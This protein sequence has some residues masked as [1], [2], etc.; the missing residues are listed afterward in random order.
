MIANLLYKMHL[1]TGL[2]YNQDITGTTRQ[3]AD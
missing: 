1:L 3:Y 2:Y